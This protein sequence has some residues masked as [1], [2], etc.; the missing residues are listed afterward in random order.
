[1]PAAPSPEQHQSVADVTGEHHP[2]T[3]LGTLLD[4]EAAGNGNEANGNAD[5]HT[6]W[7]TGSAGNLLSNPGAGTNVAMP[8]LEINSSAP[9]M[10]ADTFQFRS[11]EDPVWNT[12]SAGTIDLDGLPLS[13]ETLLAGGSFDP[14]AD[15]PHEVPPP[16]ATDHNIGLDKIL[17]AGLNADH[18]LIH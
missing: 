6:L 14:H 12:G 11:D 16:A 2:W 7:N 1:M 8:S 3:L 9:A 13:I 5:Q 18:F 17:L 10:D 15:Q 4:A